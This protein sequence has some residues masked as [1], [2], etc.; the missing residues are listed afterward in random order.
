MKP[1]L[2]TIALLATFS[3][4]SK[5]QILDSTKK[6]LSD[7]VIFTVVEKM[8]EYPGGMN[9]F[10]K[11]VGKNL[12]YPAKA[13]KNET[14][15]NVQLTF[16]VEKDGSLT[17]VRIIK[18]VSPEIDAEAIRLIKECSNWKPGVQSGRTVR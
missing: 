15:G 11:Y 9:R 7:T 6:A 10:Y 12:R 5:A 2:M 17:D 1:I 3:L 13:I 14:S 16:V 8:P 18:G 4:A